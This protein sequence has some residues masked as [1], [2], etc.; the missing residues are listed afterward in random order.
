MKIFFSFIFLTIALPHRLAAFNFIESDLNPARLVPNKEI[1]LSNF[2]SQIYSLKELAYFGVR[3][4][5]PH[6]FGVSALNST[7]LGN[8]I[9]KERKI[10]LSHGFKFQEDIYLGV[11]LNYLILTIEDYGEDKAVQIDTALEIPLTESLK[12]STLL[13]NINKTTLGKEV[14]PSGFS[15]GMRWDLFSK[16]SLSLGVSRMDKAPIQLSALFSFP[17][18]PSFYIDA[19]Y[20]DRP[21]QFMGGFSVRE[22]NVGIQYSFT[23]TAS[24]PSFHKFVLNFYW[25]KK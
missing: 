7:Q 5:L 17:I 18:H 19:S 6:R 12:F 25:S 14:L 8:S 11:N 23:Q 22:R 3:F 9:Y 13:W 10:A 21:S 20:R 24:L 1:L 16:C 15:S 2:Y 4:T